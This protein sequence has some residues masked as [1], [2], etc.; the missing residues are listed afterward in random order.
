MA[1]RVEV[2]PERVAC[3]LAWLH[4]VLRSAQRQHPRL[5]R[6]NVIDGYVEVEL[7]R[8][9]AIRPGRR[10]EPLDQLE[11]QTQPLERE[12]HPVLLIERDLAAEHSAVELSECPGVRTIEHHGA[13]ACEWHSP[14]VCHEAPAV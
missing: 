12:D 13:H 14:G 11:C 3:C 9:L 7:L 1:G 10:S 5:D 6:V 8:R 4:F 2:H